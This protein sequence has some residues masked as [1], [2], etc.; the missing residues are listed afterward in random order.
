VTVPDGTLD[1]ATTLPDE[2]AMP[3][4]PGQFAAVWNAATP[5]RR[6]QWLNAAN[7]AF[8]DSLRCVT[9]NHE[10][11]IRQSW[12]NTTHETP[13][14]TA[15]CDQPRWI[16]HDMHVGPIDG[17]D[18]M[19][20]VWHAE[21]KPQPAPPAAVV[22]CPGCPETLTVPIAVEF[23]DVAVGQQ[24]VVCKPDLTELWAHAWQHDANGDPL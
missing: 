19:R 21:A 6:G 9:T 18:Q 3:A 23:L 15:R 7:R 10:G 16:D 5:E 17:P 14:G 4:G 8:D 13:H 22:Q 12:C 24:T 20:F 2:W 11:R 1:G